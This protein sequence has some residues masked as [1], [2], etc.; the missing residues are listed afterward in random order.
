[1]DEISFGNAYIVP[2]EEEEAEKMAFA[3]VEG[4]PREFVG[5]GVK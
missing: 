2:G 3:E 4:K 1:M 5:I